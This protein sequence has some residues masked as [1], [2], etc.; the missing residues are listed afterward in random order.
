M[1]EMLGGRY[2]VRVQSF[3]TL[4]VWHSLQISKCSSIR[5][6]SKLLLPQSFLVLVQAS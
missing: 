4:S 6:L 2:W 5:K 3:H 1:E